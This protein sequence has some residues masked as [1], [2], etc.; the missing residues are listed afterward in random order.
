MNDMLGRLIISSSL[1]VQ[2]CCTIAPAWGNAPSNNVLLVTP[3]EASESGRGF[4]FFPSRA[5][6]TSINDRSL[7]TIK[8][9]SEK[10]GVS[11]PLIQSV[12]TPIPV[13]EQEHRPSKPEPTPPPQE[14]V[15]VEEDSNVNPPVPTE[16]PPTP[17]VVAEEK[18]LSTETPVQRPTPQPASKINLYAGVG[19]AIVV[20]F[21]MPIGR[22]LNHRVEYSD[23]SAYI[24]SQQNHGGSQFSERQLQQRLGLFVDWSIGTSPWSLTTGLTLNNQTYRLQA[25][26]SDTI[27]INGNTSSF[28]GQVFSID[29][30]LPKLTPY[31][32]L[33]YAR[34]ASHERGWDGFAEFGLILGALN[35]DVKV[36]TN[37]YKT[38]QQK[39]DVQ[40]EVN[41]IRKSIDKWGVIPNAI[42][43]LSY[44]Y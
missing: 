8:P 33:R 39:S 44:R 34:Q 20:G 23:G 7:E 29:Y 5:M 21:S 12:I 43:G 3:D 15:I 27:V 42:L 19:T 14:S 36:S 37:L 1:M 16:T 41:R 9:Q 11:H 38:D 18:L 10:Q 26:T 24:N 4:V 17:P 30:S 32:G 13:P 22:G 40:A 31:I 2:L 28:T 35:A 6:S 25:K